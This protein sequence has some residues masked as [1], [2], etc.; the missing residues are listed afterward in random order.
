MLKGSIL[1]K[2]DTAHRSNKRPLNFGVYYKNTLIALCHALEDFILESDSAPVMITAFQ[3]GKWYLQEAD[4]YGEIAQQSSHVVIM[5]TRDTGFVEHPTS[6]RSNVALVSLEPSDPVAQEWHLIIL[7]PKYTAMVLC[8]ELSESDYGSQGLPEHDIERKF[9]GFWTFEPDLVKEVAEIAIAHIG[10]YD[11]QLQQALT[12]RVEEIT[13]AAVTEERDDLGV[14]VHKVVDYLQD[15]QQHLFQLEDTD[16]HASEFYQQALDE[17]LVSNEM[18][19]FLRMA[20]LIDQANIVNPMVAAEV[21]AFS[22]AMGQLLDLPAW[23]LKR[24]RLAGLLHGLVP[25]LPRNQVSPQD[26]N[27]LAKISRKKPGF[28]AAGNDGPS[29]PLVSEIQALRAMPQLRAV[30]RIITHQTECWDGTGIPAELAY[31]AIP[32]ESRILGLITEFQ[33]HINRQRRSPAGEEQLI[34]T[35]EE[36]LSHALAECQALSGTAFD[37]KLIEALGLM[38]M[39]MQQGMSLQATQ[40]K[41]ASG[42]WLLDSQME[43]VELLNC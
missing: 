14:V 8:Q 9:Y 34:P 23:Q 27:N 4:R 30:A 11:Q 26:D 22:E 21:A 28:M 31:D 17:N 19:A 29:C 2:L 35:Q 12:A 24:L 3:Q 40:P 7:S 1:Q 42:M 10:G 32:L 43:V 38:V 13:A 16:D 39:G 5:A 15:S 33:R 18:Q 6:Q 36:I 37:P 25:S 41:I 20:Q